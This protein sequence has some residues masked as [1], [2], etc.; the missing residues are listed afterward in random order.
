MSGEGVQQALLK[1]LEGTVAN[2]PPQGG[3]KHPE[4]QFI[5]MNTSNIL[6]ICG[7]AFNNI[8]EIIADRVGSKSMGFKSERGDNTG[9]VVDINDPLE[10]ARLLSKVQVEDLLQFGMIPEFIGRLPVIT[11]LAPLTNEEMVR[12]LTEP[13]DAIVRQ[14]QEYFRMD[15]AKLEYT[16]EALLLIAEK[17]RKRGTGARALRSIIEDLMRDLLFDLPERKDIKEYIVTAEMVRQIDDPEP[18][19]V[20]SAG[21]DGDGNE[22]ATEKKKAKRKRAKAQ[23]ARR[24]NTA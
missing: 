4:Q 6:F 11:H 18:I 17:A 12:I 1:M 8:E 21:D 5:Q 20:K 15:G 19:E 24:K 9:G 16:P 7:G 14:Y 13:K 23:T 2:I 10:R 22:E 3:R